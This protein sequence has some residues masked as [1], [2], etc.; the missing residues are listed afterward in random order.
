[1]ARGSPELAIIPMVAAGAESLEM[2]ESRKSGAMRRRPAN[3]TNDWIAST[4]EAVLDEF[5]DK[6]AVCDMTI[7][8]LRRRSPMERCC[9][10]NLA[11]QLLSK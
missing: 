9:K 10:I 7:A 2:P 4:V 5:D 3:G 6:A 1:M 11:I 8:F